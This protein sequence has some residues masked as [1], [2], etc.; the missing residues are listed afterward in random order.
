MGVSS[1]NLFA[2]M[3]YAMFSRLD[4]LFLHAYMFR[5]TCVGFY[6]MLSFVL[7]LFFALCWC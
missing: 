2:C 7:F 4:I 3:P 6:A 5:S 1:L